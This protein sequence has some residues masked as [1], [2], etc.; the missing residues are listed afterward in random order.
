[1]QCIICR[2]EKS[3]MSD[4]HVIPESLGGY[5]HIYTVCKSCNSTMGTNVD[6]P[7]I[8]HKLAELYR[9][10]EE[11]KGKKGKIPNPFMGTFSGVEDSTDRVKLSIKSN[12]VIDTEYLPTITTREEDGRTI[13]EI[14]IDSRNED[15]IEEIT[16]KYL[17]RNNIPETAILKTE[18]TIQIK[19]G[20]VTGKWEFDILKFKIGLLKIA[21]EFA[22]DS[23]PLYINDPDAIKIATILKTADY[24]NVT[25]YVN[26]GSGLQK[27]IF[28]PFSDYLDVDSKRHYL[29]L[30][31]VGSKLLC[32]I[33]LSDLFAVGVTLAENTY[34]GL[35]EGILGIND[36]VEKKFRKM[37]MTEVINY[38]LGPLH[39][40][41][42]YY[43]NTNEEAMAASREINNP[44]FEVEESG[45][46]VIPLFQ[47]NGDPLSFATHELL[48][49]CEMIDK[50]DKNWQNHLF[51]FKEDQSYYIKSK[52][53]RRLYQVVAFE[54]SRQRIDKV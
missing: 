40:R 43:F 42:L 36:P 13:L 1:M 52:K 5:Y 53:S 47:R 28:T 51:K 30:T 35:E 8:N 18:K 7:L 6:A 37:N 46:G 31:Q 34:L 2:E 3:D 22:V 39:T 4:E 49:H 24:N 25:N 17:Q 32:L 33:K 29:V 20:W 44:S 54:M 38:C 27:E 9:F 41:F 21:Y 12:N 23:I 10:V 26:I 15:Q 45:N 16:K 14:G 19:D 48:P 11:I 50:S